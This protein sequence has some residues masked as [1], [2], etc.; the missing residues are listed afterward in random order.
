MTGRR[1][2]LSTKVLVAVTALETSILTAI[3]EASV[4]H[5]F[6]RALE[7]VTGEDPLLIHARPTFERAAF[8]MALPGR[9]D[10]NDAPSE[11]TGCAEVRTW[12]TES[13]GVP[14][15]KTSP[16]VHIQGQRST[17]VQILSMRARVVNTGKPVHATRISGCSGAG[18][19]P[20]I[21][22]GFDLESSDPAA[23]VLDEL[24]DITGRLYFEET[25]SL[26]PMGRL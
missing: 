5:F 22:I 1:R 3:G 24:G 11:G 19:S 23:R 12:L 20:T 25:Q 18:T 9:I 8:D 26:L 10:P 21:G 17:P 15:E 14:V 6:P 16:A 2:R 7:I 4:G 13:G